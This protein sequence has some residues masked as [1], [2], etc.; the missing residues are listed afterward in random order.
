MRDDERPSENPSAAELVCWTIGLPRRY[1]YRE[2]SPGDREARRSWLEA[3]AN[4]SLPTDE[5][6]ENFEERL[7][8]A[9]RHGLAPIS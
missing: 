8:R 7:L 2:L 9:A 3:V 6:C 1:T 4:R 5:K